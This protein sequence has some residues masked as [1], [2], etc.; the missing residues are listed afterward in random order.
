ME[1]G[2]TVADRGTELIGGGESASALGNI[3]FKT[4]KDMVR[5]DTVCTGLCSVSGTC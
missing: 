5:G 3:A 1:V 4:S 2:K